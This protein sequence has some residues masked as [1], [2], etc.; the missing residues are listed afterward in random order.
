MI[1]VGFDPY[2]Y[3]SKLEGMTACIDADTLIFQAACVIQE[4]FIIVQHIPTGKTKEFKNKTE[5]KDF[6]EMKEKDPRDYNIISEDSRLGE[7]VENGC[8]IVKNSINKIQELPFVKDIIIFIGGSGNYRKDRYPYYKAQRGKKPIAL[9]DIYNFVVHKYSK[10]VVICNSK[11]AEDCASI[12]NRHYLD[13]AIKTTGNPKDTKAILFGVDKDLRMIE[14]Y[15]YNYGKPELGVIWQD[16]LNCFK[17]FCMQCLLGDSTDN[18]AGLEGL[19]P[20]LKAKYNIKH[21]GIGEKT[22]KSLL[23]NCK[24]KEE[25]L[26]LVVEFYQGFYG[27]EWWLYKINEN[28]LLLNIQQYDDEYWSLEECCKKLCIPMIEYKEVK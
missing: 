16:D 4:N 12:V 5:F 22:A 23:D 11:E 9:Q 20:V 17:S 15:R 28:G 2:D 7:G 19:S 14:G 8:Y 26:A 1:D 24:T 18:I 10:D 25:M 27:S 21:K 13:E 6:L 3:S